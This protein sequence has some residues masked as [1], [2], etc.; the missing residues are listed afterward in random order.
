MARNKENDAMLNRFAAIMQRQAEENHAQMRDLLKLSQ[1][2]MEN[3][4]RPRGQYFP[5]RGGSSTWWAIISLPG[6]F[7]DKYEILNISKIIYTKF[8]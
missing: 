2:M 4:R 7:P 8:E 5:L 3:A 6:N 1:E